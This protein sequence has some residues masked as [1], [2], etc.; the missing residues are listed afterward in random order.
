MG[1]QRTPGNFQLAKNPLL[2]RT[3]IVPLSQLKSTI[4]KSFRDLSLAESQLEEAPSTANTR[5]QG[6][7]GCAPA[8][9]CP[10]GGAQEGLLGSFH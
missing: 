5:K 1:T 2:Y 3:A 7:L 9:P 10:S 6:A 4:I 8:V